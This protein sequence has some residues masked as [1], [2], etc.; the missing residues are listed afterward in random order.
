MQ[1]SAIAKGG[2]VFVLDM[3]EPVRIEDLAIAMVRM[4]GKKL[5]RDTGNSSDIEIVFAGLRPGEKMY[6]EL[7]LS[8]DFGRT[9][10]SKVFAA[11]EDWIGWDELVEHL[12][13]LQLNIQPVARD[14]IKSLLLIDD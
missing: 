1:A 3:G 6:E 8:N 4:S 11:S 10:V 13:E 14:N 12:N 2:D 5:M 7:F 9:K